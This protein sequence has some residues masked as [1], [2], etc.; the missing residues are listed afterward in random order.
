MMQVH[1]SH[2]TVVR[3]DDTRT[4][5]ER[6]IHR[7]TGRPA[8]TVRVQWDAQADVTSKPR[9]RR[10]DRPY[11]TPVVYRSQLRHTDESGTPG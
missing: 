8:A 10:R 9:R 7:M 5:V 11:L 1:G 4:A 3:G 2:G 6:V